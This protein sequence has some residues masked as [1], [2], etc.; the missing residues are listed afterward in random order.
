M[1][2]YIIGDSWGLGE[3]TGGNVTHKGLEQFFKDAD[4]NVKNLSQ[5]GGTLQDI[6]QQIK[7][8]PKNTSCKLFCFVTD[9]SR[10]K[11]KFWDTSW[12]KQD[13]IDRHRDM[14]TFY[15]K[16]YEDFGFPIYLIGGLSDLDEDLV[17]DLKNVKIA[18]PSMIKLFAPD[19]DL[20]DI[21]LQDKLYN[22][23]FMMNRDTLTWIMQQVDKW[24]T[25]SNHP[26][27]HT[28][29][30]HPDRVAHKMLFDYLKEE[31]FI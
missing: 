25:I 24:D 1:M 31:N 21:Y 17:K 13:Y 6:L 20:Y 10:S 28:D 7:S 26:R 5:G 4:M 12:V 29:R 15:F 22:L 30:C 11:L 16:L 9:T 27:F 2:N 14:L 3:I 8:I 19:A 23:P 18:C